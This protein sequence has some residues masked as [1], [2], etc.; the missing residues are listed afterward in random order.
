MLG[1]VPDVADAADGIADAVVENIGGYERRKQKPN[2]T[3]NEQLP[4]HLP[5]SR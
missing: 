2:K 4:A 3:S 1:D 5:R